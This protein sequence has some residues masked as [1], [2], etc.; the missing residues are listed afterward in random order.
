MECLSLASACKK[1]LDFLRKRFTAAGVTEREL[2]EIN[3][4]LTRQKLQFELLLLQ[5][6][7]RK[8]GLNLKICYVDDM[9]TVRSELSS[10]RLI[11]DR[12]L[13]QLLAKLSAIRYFDHGSMQFYHLLSLGQFLFCSHFRMTLVTV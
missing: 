7:M 4:E 2:R 3:V 6:D 9:K 5:H 12:R 8:F 10:G 1:E 11:T 13:D